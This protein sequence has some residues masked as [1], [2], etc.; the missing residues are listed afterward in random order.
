MRE[1]LFNTKII[2][3]G[4]F[5]AYTGTELDLIKESDTNFDHFHADEN[6]QLLPQRANKDIGK[7][8]KYGRKLLELCLI[9]GMYIPNG[10]LGQDKEGGTYIIFR[11][12][13]VFSL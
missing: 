2:L 11:R 8:I 13:N 6:S 1:K 3:A 7:I 9:T 12:I 5:N 10:R 4:D